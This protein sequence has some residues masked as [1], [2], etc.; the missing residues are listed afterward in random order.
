MFVSYQCNALTGIKN[1]F[2]DARKTSMAGLV[3]L[4]SCYK[5]VESKKTG[6]ASIL[7]QSAVPRRKCSSMCFVLQNTAVISGHINIFRTGCI[8]MY[9]KFMLLI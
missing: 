7:F 4:Y 2:K 3:A 6:R 8:F 5:R 9:K 1:G